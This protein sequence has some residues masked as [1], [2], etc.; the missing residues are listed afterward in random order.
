MALRTWYASYPLYLT[1]L[2][3]GQFG[4]LITW[5]LAQ[6][7]LG[8]K[9]Y[10]LIFLFFGVITVGFS[11]VL[12]MYMPDSPA[13]A[14]FLNK[15]DKLVA[16]ERLR[17]NQTGVVSREWRWDHL[18]E[19]VRDPKTW[20][21]FALIFCISVPS[22]GVTT[23]GPLLVKSFGFDS[24]HAI[25]FNSPFGLVQL[26]STV[27]GAFIAMKYHKKGPVIAGLAMAPIIGCLVMLA[28]PRTPDR[29][30]SLLFGYYMISVYPGIST[31]CID[32]VEMLAN[33]SQFPSSTHG[34]PPTR[35]AIPRVSVPRRHF[36]SGNRSVTLLGHFSTSLLK[37]QNTRGVCS[38]TW[39]CTAPLWSW[40][41]SRVR[42]WLTSTATTAGDV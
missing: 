33:M 24:F 28:T 36:S 39:P 2:T 19:S 21:W 20:L 32:V 5:G 27:G 10:Q 22:G 9:P 16:I 1:H 38:P 23:F 7:S 13:E 40:S 11:F 42:T 30:A 37:R 34:V 29:K 18:W 31:S 12:F 41:A 3:Q 6:L 4:S 8:L 14:K 15:H 25:L 35:A 26:F 17:M